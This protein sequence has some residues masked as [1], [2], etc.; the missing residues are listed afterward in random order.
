MTM[1]YATKQ[2]VP[3]QVKNIEDFAKQYRTF[4]IEFV[5][6]ILS[7]FTQRVLSEL[8]KQ[9]LRLVTLLNTDILS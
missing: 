9:I 5:S 1:L 3:P 7:K 4:Y 8:K 2:Q 6:Q